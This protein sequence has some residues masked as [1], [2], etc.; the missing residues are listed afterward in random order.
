MEE[1]CSS[2]VLWYGTKVTAT[3]LI[4]CS[5]ATRIPRRSSWG[6]EVSYFP[7]RLLMRCAELGK[8]MNPCTLSPRTRVLYADLCDIGT[9]AA[10]RAI[11]MNFTF[12]IVQ[13]SSMVTGY[14]VPIGSRTHYAMS[15]T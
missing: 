9:D 3:V 5:A 13:L 11:G 2:L 6:W 1:H 14:A 12:F 8:R 7:T 15:G 10:S 4:Y